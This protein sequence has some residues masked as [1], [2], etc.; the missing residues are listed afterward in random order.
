M[1]K[2]A[3]GE[4]GCRFKRFAKGIALGDDYMANDAKTVQALI[5]RDVS[6]FEMTAHSEALLAQDT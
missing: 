3:H 2:Q 5:A 4:A 1:G 6:K